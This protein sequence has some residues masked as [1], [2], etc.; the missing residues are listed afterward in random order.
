MSTS[1]LDRL[2]DEAPSSQPRRDEVLAAVADVAERLL[3]AVS[4][5]DTMPDVLERLGRSA[6]ADRAFLYECATEE[7]AVVSRMTSEWVAPG[8][9]PSIDTPLWQAYRE[10]PEDV[11]RF[12]RGE[13][14]RYAAAESAAEKRV[15]LEAE[16]TLSTLLVPVLEAGRLRALIGFDACRAARVWAPS[17]IEALRAAAGAL[18]AAVERSSSQAALR[19][20]EEILAAVATASER[21]LQAERWKDAIE[22]VLAVL[23]HATHSSRAYM[24]ET[25]ESDDGRLVS[26]MRYEWTEDGIAPTIGTP[27]WQGYEER[28]W[29]AE[30]LR[31]GE[32]STLLAADDTPAD[33]VAFDAEGT[34]VY[35]SIPIRARGRLRGYIGFDDCVTEREWSALELEALRAA[36]GTIGAA[37]ERELSDARL[38]SHERILE[39][40]AGSAER[41]LRAPSWRDAIDEVLGLLG[42]AGAASRCW[43]FE[44]EADAAGRIL[45]TLTHEWVAPGVT[46]SQVDEFWRARVEPRRAVEAFSRGEPLQ[47]LRDEAYPEARAKLAAEGTLSVICVPILV[48]GGLA[49]YIG[50]DDCETARR[51]S[52][53][54]EEALRTAASVLGSAMQRA[55]GLEAI[56]VRERILEAIAS[57]SQRALGAASVADGVR[58]ILEGIGPASSASRVVVV[59]LGE[60]DD[61]SMVVTA[62]HQWVAPG[63]PPVPESVWEGHPVPAAAASSYTR[64]EIATRLA[65]EASGASHE[66]LELSGTHSLL[67]IP[68]LVGGHVWG[69]LGFS[70]CVRPRRWELA[71]TE[72]LRA[73]AGVIAA[74]VERDRSTRA[75]RASDERLWQAQ[76]MEAIGRLSSGLAHDLRNYLAVIVN[77]ATF[78]REQLPHDGRADVDA[79]LETAGRVGDL[80]DRLVAFGRPQETVTPQIVDVGEVVR[81]VREVVGTLLPEGHSL[82]MSIDTGLDPVYIDRDELERVIVNLVLNAR[83]AMQGAGALTIAVRPDPIGVVLDVADG[84]VGM[85]EATRARALE[86]F[87]TTKAGMGTG[88]GLAIVYG[89]VSRAGGTIEIESAPGEGTCVTVRL[90]RA[91]AA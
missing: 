87:F 6:R 32:P 28:G 85:D 72:A 63:I 53:A 74:M 84:G 46:P 41:L 54:E 3:R 64:G 37:M 9:R 60:Q 49:A 66:M 65:T 20:R 91:A 77:Y 42:R 30:R 88:L 38:G 15:V 68:I 10:A 48:D 36:A 80:V 5:R 55:T 79:L 76:K 81:G 70:D 29:H 67:T 44:C 39:A 86:P 12:E 57:A 8:V 61:G 23:G 62:N 75:L 24:F 59:E 25:T 19:R 71:E 52:A 26:S 16:G 13:T 47:L 83:D 4:W 11:E 51:W 34:L 43:L 90:P 78:V 14:V 2:E 18:G 89:I 40:V 33:R 69:A 58:M 45:S 27:H 21:L 31:S 35:V 1:S 7:G 17:E 22:D 50:Y 56:R 73:T 82:S